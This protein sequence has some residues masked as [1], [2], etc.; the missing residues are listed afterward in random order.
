MQPG[1]VRTEAAGL[2]GGRLKVRVAALLS[3]LDEL[4]DQRLG[5]G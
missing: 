5:A 1:A 4:I 3:R 2:H